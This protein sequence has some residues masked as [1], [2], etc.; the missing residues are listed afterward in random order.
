MDLSKIIEVLRR[1]KERTQQHLGIVD[2]R[3][4]E[5]R[6]RVALRANIGSYFTVDGAACAR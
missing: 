6:C 4:G 1:E 3:L 5:P 2:L